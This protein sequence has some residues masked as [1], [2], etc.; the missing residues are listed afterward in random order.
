MDVVEALLDVLLS[1]CVVMLC[2]VV[3]LCCGVACFV[4]CCVSVI[5]ILL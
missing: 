4:L 1:G 3:V 2:C 5:F